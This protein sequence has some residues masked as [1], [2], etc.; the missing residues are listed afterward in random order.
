MAPQNRIIDFQLI[1]LP[2]AGLLDGLMQESVKRTKEADTTRMNQLM[3]VKPANASLEQT[4]V[5]IFHA[6]PDAFTTDPHRLRTGVM[7]R[8]PASDE[9]AAVDRAAAAEELRRATELWR[10]GHVS[11]AR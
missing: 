11:P 9:L 8:I 10:A 2:L 6:N 4:I 7:L 1:W 3:Q 5:G